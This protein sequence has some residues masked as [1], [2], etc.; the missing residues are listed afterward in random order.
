MASVVIRYITRSVEED[1][2]VV[3]MGTEGIGGETGVAGEVAIQ[4]GSAA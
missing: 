1:D 3:E 2:W 4:S